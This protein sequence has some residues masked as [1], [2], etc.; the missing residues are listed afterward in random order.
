MEAPL[1]IGGIAGVQGRRIMV[2]ASPFGGPVLI[3]GHALA[4]TPTRC[5]DQRGPEPEGLGGD[6]QIVGTDAL[7]RRLEGGATSPAVAAS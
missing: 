6:Q 1:L 4:R 2:S 5:R 7:A 3:R